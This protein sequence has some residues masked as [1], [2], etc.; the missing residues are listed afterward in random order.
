MYSI[1]Q[2]LPAATKGQRRA[3][4]AAWVKGRWPFAQA[5]QKKVIPEYDDILATCYCDQK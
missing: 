5:Q 1:D 4:N 2:S 3:K